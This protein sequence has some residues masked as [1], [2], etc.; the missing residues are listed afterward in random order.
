MDI[1]TV[2]LVGFILVFMV[3]GL[4]ARL[5]FPLFMGLLILRQFRKFQAEVARQQQWLNAHLQ[6]LATQP[7]FQDELVRRLREMG[8]SAKHVRPNETGLANEGIADLLSQVGRNYPDA[9]WSNGAHFSGNDVV[10]PNGPSLIG[11][12]LYVP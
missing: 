3:I 9:H 8:E 7:D 11:G 10:I 5:I 6:Q 12:R 2:L 4:F 1:F